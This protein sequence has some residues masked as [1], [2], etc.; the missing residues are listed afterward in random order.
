MVKK[1]E[2]SL[3]VKLCSKLMKKP[4]NKHLTLAWSAKVVEWKREF[5]LYFALGRPSTAFSVQILRKIIKN[6]YNSNVFPIYIKDDCYI[7]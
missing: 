1:R 2:Y 3:S 5:Y 6:I 4:K 7:N